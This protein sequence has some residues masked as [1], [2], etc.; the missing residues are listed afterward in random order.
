MIPLAGRLPA[1]LLL[2]PR[3]DGIFRAGALRC[4]DFFADFPHFTVS[5]VRPSKPLRRRDLG[6]DLLFWQVKR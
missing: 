2:S 4:S 1:R 5:V 6:F 3:Y